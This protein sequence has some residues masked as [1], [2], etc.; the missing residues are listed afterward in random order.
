MMND[1]YV[2]V[3]VF[4]PGFGRESGWAVQLNPDDSHNLVLDN[5][6]QCISDGTLIHI[7]DNHNITKSMDPLL[8]ELLGL[9]TWPVPKSNEEAKRLNEAYDEQQRCG[10]EPDTKRELTAEDKK[11][12]EAMLDVRNRLYGLVD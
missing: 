11:I 2:K 12:M 4:Q 6:F 1:D 3:T 5:D 7:D 8:G 10:D 9:D